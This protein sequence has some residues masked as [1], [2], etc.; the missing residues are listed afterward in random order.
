[1]AIK[2]T[3][4]QKN[5]IKAS[6]VTLNKGDISLG[7]LNDVNDV[8]LTDGAMMIYNGATGK[9]DITPKIENENLVINGGNY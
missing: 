5:R 1:M 9:Y 6:T 8:D 7:D 3:V 4:N 2:A